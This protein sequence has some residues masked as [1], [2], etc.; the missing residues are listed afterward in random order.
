MASLVIARAY[1]AFRGL[2]AGFP[3]PLLFVVFGG[4]VTSASPLRFSGEQAMVVGGALV[5][6][7]CGAP[8]PP[9]QEFSVIFD[10]GSTGTRVHVIK[11]QGVSTSALPSIERIDSRKVEPGL[12]SFRASPRGVGDSLAPLLHF[13]KDI[14][15]EEQHMATPVLLFGT[16]G[17]RLLSDAEQAAVYHEAKAACASAGLAVEPGSFR[18]LD[19]TDEG[20]YGLLAVIWLS[21]D[22]RTAIADRASAPPMSAIGVLDLG[23]GS[24]QIA[25]PVDKLGD[26]G[27]SDARPLR[28]PGG[29]ET[30]FTR[31]HLGFGNRQALARTQAAAR[32]SGPA[33]GGNVAHPCFHTGYSYEDDGVTYTGTSDVEAC[34]A[35]VR[36][37]FSWE[38]EGGDD[39]CATAKP[40]PV[41]C[42]TFRRGLAPPGKVHF[43]GLSAFFYIVNFLSFK[44]PIPSMPRPSLETIRASA[45]AVCRRAW[46]EIKRGGRDPFTPEH[47]LPQR[48][49]DA[50]YMLALLVDGFGFD[51]KDAQVEFVEQLGKGQPEWPYGAILAHML[52]GTGSAGRGVAWF[53]AGVL[54][55]A[56][57]AC[58]ATMVARLYRPKVMRIQVGSPRGHRWQGLEAAPKSHPSDTPLSDDSDVAESDSTALVGRA[59]A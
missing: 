7:L 49:F 5:V 29:S 48:C 43:Y 23:G 19:G 14:I 36:R 40:N 22:A 10:A 46:A 53:P 39:L 30:V 24:A 45:D 59:G 21:V 16:A 51:E 58:A 42:P 28:L 37:L 34:R 56:A 4:S 31:S 3:P 12:S 2:E 8:V 50:Q 25:F 6:V 26:V 41:Q 47:K 13:A 57:L 52:S 33:H 55:L 18:T 11:F 35:L 20:F 32:E 27:S 44:E 9:G 38:K 17:M 1:R 15:P 54:G